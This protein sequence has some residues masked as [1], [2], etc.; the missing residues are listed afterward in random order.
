MILQQ[1]EI[2]YATQPY[3]TALYQ[4]MISTMYFGLLRISEVG[5]SSHYILAKDVHIGFNKKK[6]LFVLRLSKT[7]GK[8]MDP[9]LIKISSV[10]NRSKIKPEK[11]EMPCPYNLIRQY[12]KM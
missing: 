5:E 8:H 9:Q 4:V 3:L 6:M 2:Q 12:A 10:R 7:H 11:I 1:V